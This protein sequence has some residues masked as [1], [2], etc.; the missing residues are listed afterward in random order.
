MGEG[1]FIDASEDIFDGHDPRVA[2]VNEANS[3]SV[4]DFDGDGRQD[5]YIGDQGI[6]A[7]PWGGA[8]NIMLIQSPEGKMVDEAAARI[9]AELGF[10]HDQSVGDIDGDGDIDILNRHAVAPNTPVNSTHFYINDGTGHF[11]K[12]TTRIPLTELIGLSEDQSIQT[13]ELVDLDAD[14]DLILDSIVQEDGRKMMRHELPSMTAPGISY[15]SQKK[16][17]LQEWVAVADSRM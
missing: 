17:S 5:L 9:P 4:A 16:R 3:W 1:V 2:S 7:S 15:L 12:D 10:T 13:V 8:Q 14:G 11:E 6:D